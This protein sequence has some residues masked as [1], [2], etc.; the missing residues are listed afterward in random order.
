MEDAERQLS[1]TETSTFQNAQL[2]IYT[3]HTHPHNHPFIHSLT[4]SPLRSYSYGSVRMPTAYAC[5]LK[6]LHGWW[7]QNNK[8]HNNKKHKHCGRHQPT[9]ASDTNDDDDNDKYRKVRVECNYFRVCLCVCVGATSLQCLTHSEC[10][11]V[12]LNVHFRSVFALPSSC[13]LL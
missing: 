3:V 2:V 7:G 13:A 12:C 10:D 4:Q 9:Q 8:C 11:C 6:L 1:M 5:G